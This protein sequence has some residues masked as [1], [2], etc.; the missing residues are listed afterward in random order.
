MEKD[1]ES[2]TSPG[3]REGIQHP[4]AVNPELF[5]SKGRKKKRL[6]SADRYVEGILSGN[7]TILSE[8]ITL[9][10]S[11]LPEHEA[12]ALEIIGK[13]L[14]HSGRSVRIGI[15]G[16]PGAGKSTFIETFGLHLTRSGKKLAVLTI[17]P[18]SRNSG[19]SILGDKTR[20]EKLSTDPNAFIRPSPSA[21]ASGGVAARTGESILLCEAAGFDTIIVETVGVGQSETTVRSMV[22]F[23]LLLMLAGTGD[24]LQGIKRGVMEMADAVAVNKADGDNVQKAELAKHSI[25]NALNL[26]PV[27]RPGWNPRALTCSALEDRGM[28]ELIGTIGDFVAVTKKNGYFDE[29]RKEQ[30]V[31]RMHETI[32]EA[33]IGSFYR[34]EKIREMMS[35]LEDQLRNGETTPFKAA[36]NLIGVYFDR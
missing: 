13:C 32:S 10:E 33:L 29:Q 7:R 2:G 31:I 6:F 8:A 20:M 24:E 36:M 30:D 21:G 12:V 22:D 3:V 1:K 25:Q 35:R 23:F 18:S 4:P 17:D 16:I 27:L 15:T 5:A 11:S 19:G 26:F 9:V 28:D 34:N 14:P